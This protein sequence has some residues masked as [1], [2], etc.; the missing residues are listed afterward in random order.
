MP[1]ESSYTKEELISLLKQKDEKAFTYLYENYYGSMCISLRKFVKDEDLINDIVQEGFIAVWNSINRYENLKGG[2]YNWMKSV[3]FHTAVNVIRRESK[4]R[5]IEENSTLYY[6]RIDISDIEKIDGIGV[7]KIV[8]SLDEK[9]R[10]IITMHYFEGYPLKEMDVN[11]VIARRRLNVALE[12]LKQSFNDPSKIQIKEKNLANAKEV[13]LGNSRR[14][15]D[16]ATAKE[17][18]EKEYNI[19]IVYQSSLTY[20]EK[21][22][23]FLSTGEAMSAGDI[24]KKISELEPNMSYSKTLKV[25]RGI[26][27]SLSRFI[28]NKMVKEVEARKFGFG[29]TDGRKVIINQLQVKN[30]VP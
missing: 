9:H 14:S 6:R 7:K 16:T 25:K 18:K 21:C 15:E 17:K 30:K 4:R 10:R 20:S 24:F 28:E 3:M 8:N 19:P 13:K 11:R 23:Y 26:N 12:K 1:P 29:D 5:F 27:N 22:L 2:I